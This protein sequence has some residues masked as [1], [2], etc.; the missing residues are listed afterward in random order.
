MKWSEGIAQCEKYIQKEAGSIFEDS[1]SVSLDAACQF[2]AIHALQQLDDLSLYATVDGR[3]VVL[4][5]PWGVYVTG[6]SVNRSDDRIA[7]DCQT[8]LA[9]APVDFGEHPDLFLSNHRTLRG[10]IC[11]YVS[12]RNMGHA[13]LRKLTETLMNMRAPAHVFEDVEGISFLWAELEDLSPLLLRSEEMISD[14]GA[15]AGLSGPYELTVSARGL[16]KKALLAASKMDDPGISIYSFVRWNLLWQQ[17][18]HVLKSTSHTPAEF[19]HPAISQMVQSDRDNSTEY[20]HSLAVFLRSGRRLREASLQLGVHRNTLD[21]RIRRISLLYHVDLQNAAIC[22]E[23]LFSIHLVERYGELNATSQTADGHGNLAQVQSLLW[24]SLEEREIVSS[25]Q[26]NCVLL[27]IH[28]GG[29]SEEGLTHILGKAKTAFPQSVLAFNDDAVFLAI[30]EDNPSDISSVAREIVRG[31]DLVGVL[32][33][34]FSING[35]GKRVNLLRLCLPTIHSMAAE[36]GLV[37]IQDYLSNLFFALLQSQ[38]TL[39]FYYCDQVIQVMDLDYIHN[40]NLSRCLYAY[41]TNFMDMGSAAD[42]VNI[43]RN[44]LEYHL[45]RIMPLVGGMPSEQLRFEMICTY[46]MLLASGSDRV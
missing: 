30:M 19:C 7:A 3:T 2:E 35:I 46:R 4:F 34:P 31:T 18:D 24:A 23:L 27:M 45:K 44:T 15:Y 5:H 20:I 1:R 8:I 21:Y 14:F 40:S 28:T 25:V 26:G 16:M 9:K 38:T 39:S 33:P 37:F 6:V 13:R 43:H 10:I 17:A 22:F 36:D 29:Q 11:L 32:T 42:A 12:R 41:L